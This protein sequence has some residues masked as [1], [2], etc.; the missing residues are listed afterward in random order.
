MGVSS[1]PVLAL[2]LQKQQGRP[3]TRKAK[4]P[5]VTIRCQPF[6]IESQLDHH[7]KPADTCE[8]RSDRLWLC[9]Q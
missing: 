9:N 5:A 3:T 2:R 7:T 8:H 4:R 6:A 1:L